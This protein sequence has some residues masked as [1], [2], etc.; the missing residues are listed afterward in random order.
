[1]LSTMSFSS[2]R[3]FSNYQFKWVIIAVKM[4]NDFWPFKSHI[5]KENMAMNIRLGK[6]ENK[7]KLTKFTTQWNRA[8]DFFLTLTVYLL[9]S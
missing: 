5:P 3:Y 4:T 2:Y 6:Q 8:M 7:K 1:M 9:S